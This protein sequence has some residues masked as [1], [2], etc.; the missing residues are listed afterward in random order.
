MAR[1]SAALLLGTLAVLFSGADAFYGAYALS[2][3]ISKGLCVASR[4]RF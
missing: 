1:L 3:A 2:H 4:R